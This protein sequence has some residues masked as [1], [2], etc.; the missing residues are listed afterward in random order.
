M[1][2]SSDRQTL[3][4]GWGGMLR[5][6]GWPAFVAFAIVVSAVFWGFGHSKRVFRVESDI[7]FQPN[8]PPEIIQAARD[9]VVASLRQSLPDVD[10]SNS[11]T[12]IRA[13]ITTD[14][15]NQG[16]V[17]L[18]NAL[19]AAAS[20]GNQVAL[21]SVATQR[22]QLTTRAA[23]AAKASNAAQAL[24]DKLEQTYP[25]LADGGNNLNAK[26]ERITTRQEE[27]SARR[28]VV[29]EQISRTEAYAKK[30]RE[31]GTSAA[32]PAPAAN[33][34]APA[35]PAVDRDP[36]VMQL[37]AQMQLLDDQLDEQLTRLRRTEQHPYVVDLR[38]R[39]AALQQK[40]RAARER[41]GAGQPP[42]AAAV[43]AAN[44]AG[45][46]S[47]ANMAVQAAEFQLQQLISERDQIA[48]ELTQLK[49]QENLQRTQIEKLRPAR[50]QWRQA[51]EKASSLKQDR[52]A[53]EAKLRA[54]DD[55]ARA[56]TGGPLSV[57]DIGSGYKKPI[58]PRTDVMLLTAMIAGALAALI[59]AWWLEMTDRTYQTPERFAA[60]TKAPI[61]GVV[62]EIYSPEQWKQRRVWQWV[63]RPVVVVI[64][65]AYP[66]M[67]AW[68]LMQ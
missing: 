7:G 63:G 48:A 34:A 10:I 4:R 38:T 60:L 36:E 27:R 40:L 3:R 61:L 64:L 8:T 68:T 56:G 53:A 6:R 13:R 25:D 23:D 37:V 31:L 39:Q 1:V 54:F 24:L 9:K 57:A 47:S 30:M 62:D 5:Y 67:S 35:T 20:E 22:E 32:V 66:V 33:P 45:N 12:R 46:A 26:L 59:T 50:D 16:Y 41:A 15:P 44:N 29:E 49:D 17:V 52:D 19:E 42:P 21:S 2:T 43:A 14:N 55:S 51:K 58:W 65:L 28:K 18:S 11:D